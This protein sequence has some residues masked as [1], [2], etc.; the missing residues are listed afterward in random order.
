MCL[1]Y[2]KLGVMDDQKSRKQKMPYIVDNMLSMQEFL[3]SGQLN[4]A[5][6]WY[7]NFLPDNQTVLHDH[8]E[9]N[10]CVTHMH[11]NSIYSNMYGNEASLLLVT[12][13]FGGG[14]RLS[15][16]DR[17][18]GFPIKNGLAGW[19]REECS[20]WNTRW[21]NTEVKNSTY[22][23]ARTKSGLRTTA[24]SQQWGSQFLCIQLL[25][26]GPYFQR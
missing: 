19:W 7:T 22:I 3:M 9:W 26:L 2:I 15:E 4:I 5:V 13:N 10:K 17:S 24:A 16:Q 14:T 23:S 20:L 12:V 18:I 6:V 8:V 1:L 21:W 11:T 25:Q